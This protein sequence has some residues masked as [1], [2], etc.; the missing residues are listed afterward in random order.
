MMNVKQIITDTDAGSKGLRMKATVADTPD[1]TGTEKGPY[2][3]ESDGYTDTRFTGRQTYLKVES[4]FD[5]E[6]RFGEIR[7]DAAVSGSR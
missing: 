3:L 1:G 6:W 5:Q 7:F 2:A 4:P